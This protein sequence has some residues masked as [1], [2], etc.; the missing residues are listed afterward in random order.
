MNRL[1]FGYLFFVAFAANAQSIT[2]TWQL[3][4]EKTC[5]QSA[6]E[7]QSTSE[8]ED[9]LLSQMGATSSTRVAKI[10]RFDRKGKGEEGIFNKGKRRGN[11][12]EPFRYQIQGRE[13]QFLDRKSGI[14][15]E[16]YTI[17]ELTETTL[18]IHDA[19]KDCE[20]KVFSKVKD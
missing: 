2:G 1:F 9:E 5:F 16:R 19:K 8:T 18:R 15:V 17:E 3:V 7:E 11:N 10:I 20:M 13:L 4:E 14:I 6:L 12:L